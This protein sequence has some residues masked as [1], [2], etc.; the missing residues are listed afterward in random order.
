[1]I[2]MYIFSQTKIFFVVGFIFI[3]RRHFPKAILQQISTTATD[4]LHQS[5]QKDSW[6][7]VPHSCH[8]QSM[9]QL[10]PVE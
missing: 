2:E 10:P 9:L 1:M 8:K 5:F 4:H 6:L 3:L 7:Q